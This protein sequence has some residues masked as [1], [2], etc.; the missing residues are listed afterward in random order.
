MFLLLLFLL[1]L[2]FLLLFLLLFLIVVVFR[3][4]VSSHIPTYYK[5]FVKTDTECDS[6]Y[7]DVSL[8]DYEEGI[9][10]VSTDFVF[11]VS[12]YK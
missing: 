9:K 10:C 4:S 12:C 1:L 8:V 7:V 2:P 3:Y 5:K 11:K 6:L